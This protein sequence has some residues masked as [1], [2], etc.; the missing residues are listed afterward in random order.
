[1][2]FEP[3]VNGDSSFIEEIVASK[4]MDSCFL[5]LHTHTHAHTEETS[6]GEFVGINEKTVMMK[7]GLCQ[8]HLP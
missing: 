8:P 7:D 2:K 1:M 6:E 3:N 4:N 5:R